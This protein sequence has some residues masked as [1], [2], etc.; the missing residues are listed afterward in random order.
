MRIS[1][2]GISMIAVAVV[3]LAVSYARKTLPAERRWWIPLAMIPI[4]VLLL[5][6]PISL[7]VWNL[8]P[9][10]RFLQFP[11]RWL[12]VLEAPMAIFFATAVWPVR[13]WR[14]VAAAAMCSAVFLTAASVAALVF[15][16]PCDDD[17]NIFTLVRI[18]PTGAG[19]E[20]TDEY[21][22]LG[23]DNSL[24]VT[25]MPGACLVT[26][27]T[28]SMGQA[29]D[30]TLPAWDAKSCDETFAASPVRVKDHAEHLHIVGI[31]DHAGYLVLRLRTYPAWQIRVNGRPV[32][33]LPHRDDGL[34]AVPVPA[35]PVDLTVDWVTTPDVRA[36]R[37][38]S[39]VAVI[40]LIG[41][42]LAERRL[43][44]TGL[45]SK[46]CLST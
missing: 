28:I 27:P 12:V 19:F 24:A 26:D 46:E 37:W 35:A 36:A 23:A 21:A 6:L 31:P 20:G 10:L 15:F 30:D 41:L 22:P 8:L 18:Y 14:R 43:R 3:G 40:A 4:V 2:I 11:W 5:Q 17:D 29:A 39:G 33:S 34:I 42:W 25:G 44:R 45:S 1:V 13:P 16:Q 32:G 9:K 38:I 7:P